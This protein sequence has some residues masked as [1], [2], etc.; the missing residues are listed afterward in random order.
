MLWEYI[1]VLT[2]EYKERKHTKSGHILFLN[3][4]NIQQ[5]AGFPEAFISALLPSPYI[6][7]N[8][9]ERGGV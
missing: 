8:D 1:S 6:W 2:S 4:H 7:E 3:I 9:R 5:N